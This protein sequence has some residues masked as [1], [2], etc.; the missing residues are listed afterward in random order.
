MGKRRGRHPEKALSAVQVRQIKAAGRYADGNGLYLIVDPSGARRWV[1]RTIIKG[2]RRDIG[3]GGVSLVSLSEARETA[4]SYRKVAREGGDP[5]AE[6]LKTEAP[7]PTFSA[8]A[9][10]VF[11]EHKGSWRNDKHT[12]QWITTLRTY[13]FPVIGSRPIDQI[14]APDILQVLGPIWLTKPETARRVRQRMATVLDWAKVAG[15]RAG[16]NP[17][18]GVT[19]GLPKQAGK[20]DHHAA[21]AYGDVPAFVAGLSQDGRK[22]GCAPSLRVPDLNGVAH[23]RGAGYEVGG[24]G[25]G[26][27]NLGRPGGADEGEACASGAAVAA[28]HGDFRPRQAAWGE[29]HLHLPGPIR[30]QAALEHGLPDGLA[31]HEPA[32]D[33]AWVSFARFA[34]G[35]RN[36]PASHARF[37][38][39]RLPM[40]S[41][42]VSKPP[43]GEAT[44]SRRGAS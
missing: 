12:A 4:W 42:I 19:K 3:L 39:R 37:A 40:L 5:V 24:G 31:P 32:G 38:R 8:A 27:P 15:F 13:A 35:R 20:D 16:E 10:Q 30:R 26:W 1:L 28:L 7:I 29:E 23:Q 36:K 2:R 41:K 14:E 44:C 34:T 18:L 21:L 11:E 22:R 6:K 25:R 9:E 17:V 33:S 43:T